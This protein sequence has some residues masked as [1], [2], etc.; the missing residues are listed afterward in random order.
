MI[1]W[2]LH[3]A[4]SWIMCISGQHC[5]LGIGPTYSLLTLSRLATSLVPH[6]VGHRKCDHPG[7]HALEH[8][9]LPSLPHFPPRPDQIGSVQLSPAR[10]CAALRPCTTSSAMFDDTAPP[11]WAPPVPGPCPEPDTL[12]VCSDACSQKTC[13][14]CCGQDECEVECAK[15][16]DGFVDCDDQDACTRPDCA[17][18]SCRD[19]ASPCFDVTCFQGFTDEEIAAAAHLA[20]SNTMPPQTWPEN[21]DSTFADF[22]DEYNVHSVDF[23]FDPSYSSHQKQSNPQL[24]SPASISSP[25]T[26]TAMSSLGDVSRPAKRSKT[27]AQT[28]HTSDDLDFTWMDM[29]REGAFYDRSSSSHG[30]ASSIPTP[31]SD[32]SMQPP[33]ANL[34][35]SNSLLHCHWGNDCDEEFLNWFALD[36]HIFQNHVK[37][38]TEI[39]CQWSSCEEATDPNAILDHVKYNH[40][41]GEGEHVCLWSGCNARFR[42]LHDL[43]SHFQNTHI[44]PAPLY[45]QWEACGALADDPNDLSMHLQTDHLIDPATMPLGE[46]QQTN[47]NT[48]DG[49]KTC[50]WQDS[51][52]A[53][54]GEP[55]SSCGKTF[56]TAEALQVHLKTAHIKKLKKDT[57]Y[58]CQWAH[59]HRQGAT[60]FTQ[61]GKLERHLQVHT[62]CKQDHNPLIFCIKALTDDCI[63]KSCHCNFCGK[64]FSAPQALQQHERTHTGEKPFR[65]ETCGK[66]FAQ[67]SAL[68]ECL[69]RQAPYESESTY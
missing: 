47:T 55:S 54:N 33:Q 45:C 37:P 44:A 22:L 64:V 10:C 69:P 30:H 32:A 57:G 63:V 18:Q 17:D 36:D 50:H 60:P 19:A 8:H 35:H 1:I 25:Q 6:V 20:K 65:C 62:G 5:W 12:S 56:P 2:T 13:S 29:N 4:T 68:S 14:D 26:Y 39:N 48:A 59:C 7:A 61:K 9:A 67:G 42:H 66:E 51:N 40:H 15:S 27:T 28:E 21:P 31:L 34:Q 49:Q 38:Q 24:L 58:V 43:E 16:C 46:T 3:Q 11:P 52:D 23:D 41:M 53:Q